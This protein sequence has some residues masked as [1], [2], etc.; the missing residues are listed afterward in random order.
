M[1]KRL[2]Q[3]VL[4]GFAGRDGSRRVGGAA[5]ITCVLL[6]PLIV[7][8]LAGAP[9]QATPLVSFA[10]S[11]PGPMVVAGT[12]SLQVDLQ[13]LQSGGADA[14]AITL[15]FATS[16]AVTGV[17]L[18]GFGSAVSAPDSFFGTTSGQ[19]FLIASAPSSPGSFGADTNFTVATLQLTLD[20]SLG[21]TGSVSLVDL[22]SLAGA[23]AL[24]M[25][26]FT[27]IPAD[28]SSTLQLSVVPEPPSLL[29]LTLAGAG[30]LT[31]RRRRR[32]SV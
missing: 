1:R 6:T 26:G 15:G 4:D 24:E 9:A 28:L 32:L 11:Q 13:A 19:T 12:T 22:S 21:N 30:L 18:Q 5:R 3:G 10:W 23:P 27:T 7:A 25:D 20:T 17:S 14:A 31:A 2:L 16:G 8:L 29:L